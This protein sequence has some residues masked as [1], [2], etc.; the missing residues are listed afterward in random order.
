MRDH[1]SKTSFLLRRRLDRFL[2][3]MV[4]NVWVPLYTSVAFSRMRYSAC[5]ANR[6]WQDSL[7]NCFIVGGATL[8]CLFLIRSVKAWV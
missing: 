7:L 8:G 4:P 3:Q 5:V 1:V 6:K 2:H